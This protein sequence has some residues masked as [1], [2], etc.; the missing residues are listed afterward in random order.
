MTR[1][2]L[3]FPE[4]QIGRGNYGVVYRAKH[5]PTGMLKCRI[6]AR[7]IFLLYRVRIHTLIHDL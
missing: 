2:V 6:L 1:S 4:L 3:S 7:L 5:I